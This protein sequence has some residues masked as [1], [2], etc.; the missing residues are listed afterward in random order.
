MEDT[1]DV[2]YLKKGPLFKDILEGNLA[3]QPTI[4][5]FENSMTKVVIFDLY[6]AQLNRY[7]CSLKG[8]DHVVIDIDA[9]DDPP[10]ANSKCQGRRILF[11]V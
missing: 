2:N 11:V 10:M 3:S 8:K 7:V 9:T 4:S 1:N 6:Y 5:R